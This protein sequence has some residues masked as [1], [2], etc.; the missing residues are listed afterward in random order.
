MNDYNTSEII[1]GT[2]ELMYHRISAISPNQKNYEIQVNSL[3]A[4]DYM[5]NIG[6]STPYSYFSTAFL[7]SNPV[8]DPDDS[9]LKIVFQR[10][11]DS[12]L[13]TR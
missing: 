8:A 11:L 12:T 5:F 9:I 7:E 2:S 4:A 6:L 13:N 10:S 3:S 1:S